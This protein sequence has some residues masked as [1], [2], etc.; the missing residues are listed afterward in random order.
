MLVFWIHFDKVPLV[1]LLFSF[2]VLSGF[3]M[4]WL[5]GAAYPTLLLLCVVQCFRFG[6]C[7]LGVI[8]SL[9]PPWPPP[10]VTLHL[11]HRRNRPLWLIFCIR[12]PIHHLLMN[13]FFR[14][15]CRPLLCHQ[16]GSSA[17]IIVSELSLP[18]PHRCFYFVLLPH[19]LRFLFLSLSLTSLPPFFNCS[20]TAFFFLFVPSPFSSPC[21]PSTSLFPAISCLQL[22]SLWWTSACL[23]TRCPSLFR[24]FL[25]SLSFASHLLL[26]LLIHLNAFSYVL[27]PW[28][29]PL[30][31]WKGPTLLFFFAI[32]ISSSPCHSLLLLLSRLCLSVL[33]F[34]SVLW[35][36]SGTHFS[37]LLFFCRL[38]LPITL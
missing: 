15:L 3:L 24:L 22:S 38:F 37:P 1:W 10:G 19:P 9:S 35:K 30:N 11:I 14:R 7:S 18:S 4:K 12:L 32:Y 29:S 27:L 25:V 31:L 5:L 21:H 17:V 26:F 36:S 2:G 13:A 8:Y 28:R 16:F 33:V 23:E 20:L 6:Y 34:T